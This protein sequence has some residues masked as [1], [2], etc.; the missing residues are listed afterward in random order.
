MNKKDGKTFSWAICGLIGCAFVLYTVGNPFGAWL[1]HMNGV[2]ADDLPY[3][4]SFTPSQNQFAASSPEA[5]GEALTTE[6]NPISF[7]YDDLTAADGCWEAVAPS[8]YFHNTTPISG[9]TGIAFD[10][11]DANG[12][13]LS[14]GWQ[15]RTSGAIS[16]RVTG[17]ALNSTTSSYNFG[18][19]FPD[20][21]K[22]ENTSET[23]TVR[24]TSFTLTYSCSATIDPYLGSEGLQFTLVPDETSYSIS[25]YTGSSAAVAIPSRYSGKDVTSIGDNA[26]ASR[27]TLTSVTIPNSVT[28]IG[29]YAFESCTS[30]PSITIPSSVTSIGTGS[31]SH[32]EA[33]SSIT[34]PNSVTSIGDLA[35]D[36]CIRLSSITIPSSVTAISNN[37][38]ENCTALESV[39]IPNSVTSIGD[40]AFFSCTSLTSIAI[41][42]SVTSIG[43]GAFNTCTSLTSITIPNSV[44]SIG[45]LAFYFCTSLTSI[46]I[47][48]SVT[49]IGDYAFSSCILLTSINV[50]SENLHYQSING[51]LY[52]EDG[53]TLYVYCPGQTASSFVVPN[54]VTSIGKAAFAACNS[55]T[56]ITIPN[57]VTSI[58]DNAFNSCT[59]L[60]S[61]TIPSSVTSIGETAF[62][63]CTSLTSITIPNSVTVISNQT[64]E[65]CTLLTSVT[66]PNSVTSIGDN[67][68]HSCTSLPSITIPSSVTLM[69]DSAFLSCTSLTINCQAASQPTGWNSN[70]NP[71][72]RP[73]NWNVA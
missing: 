37:I 25:G 6:G 33:L 31:F 18:N 62:Y 64:F 57:S 3:S 39:T 51:N 9:I 53:T 46:T 13:S 8:G 11:G 66:I 71:D 21:F 63:S 1:S 44:T 12:I 67:A 72:G 56:S 55:L 19:E 23:K 30:L 40:Y 5:I 22:V 49:S 16:Y 41:P 10:F 2:D 43:L 69:G 28:S 42:D 7:T 29:E 45:E 65:N 32:C 58:G 26:F 59:S 54:A 14:Y 68:F 17:V 36:Y 20:C 60:P 61:I 4:L 73:V 48:N 35:F 38:F 52:S 27:T 70:W 24:I 34:I 15:D 50:A 47:P